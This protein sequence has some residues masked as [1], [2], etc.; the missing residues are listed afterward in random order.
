MAG[1][2]GRSIPIE[3]PITID[4]IVEYAESPVRRTWITPLGSRVEDKGVRFVARSVPWKHAILPTYK[5]VS[6]ALEEE[7]KAGLAERAEAGVRREMKGK[8]KGKIEDIAKAIVKGLTR[9]VDEFSK[10]CAGVKG[11]TSAR[12]ACREP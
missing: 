12:C 2:A 5:N 11:L 4:D 9:A 3:S 10:P 8:Y 6:K 1:R 7:I